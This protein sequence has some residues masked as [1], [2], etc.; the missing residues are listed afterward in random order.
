MNELYIKAQEIRVLYRC[1]EIS[2][3][4]AKKLIKPYADYFNA[5]SIELAKKYNQR[6]KKFNFNAFMR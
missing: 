5:K 6:P 2:R 1:G 3:D 4:E